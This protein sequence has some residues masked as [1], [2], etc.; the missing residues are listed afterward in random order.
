MAP[1][2]FLMP[3]ILSV[4]PHDTRAYTQGLVW[5]EGALYESAGLHR[6]SSLRQVDPLTG[7]VLRQIK[8]PD[9][10]FAEGLALVGDLLVQL[11]WQEE[12]AFVYDRETFTTLG[13]FVYTG[14]GWGLC[15]DG[16]YLYMSDGSPTITLRDRQFAAWGIEVTLAYLSQNE[17]TG[18]ATTQSI[19]SG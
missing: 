17:R 1:V 3:E 15:F 14:E 12:L 16:Q 6:Q 13:V 4:V 5:H 7:E 10:F 2:E 18:Y 19:T 11:T 9:Q 8:V